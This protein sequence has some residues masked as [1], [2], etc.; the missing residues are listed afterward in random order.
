MY[1]FLVSWWWSIVTIALVFTPS[2]LYWIS[3]FFTS[4]SVINYIYA[5]INDSYTFIL[6]DVWSSLLFD[7]LLVYLKNNLNTNIQQRNSFFFVFKMPLF[8]WSPIL[9]LFYVQIHTERLC[10]EANEYN[11]KYNCIV[12]WTM[13]IAR[14]ICKSHDMLQVKTYFHIYIYKFILVGDLVYGRCVCV[15]IS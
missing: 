15:Y 1:L 11:L 9:C 5:M 4:S 14:I 6:N 2:I 12:Q 7:D 8:F 13:K 10:G 3:W